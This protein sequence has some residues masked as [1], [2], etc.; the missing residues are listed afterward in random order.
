MQ[1][2]CTLSSQM[3]FG[4][5]KGLIKEARMTMVSAYFVDVAGKEG[6]NTYGGNA[7]PAT[8][9]QTTTG[10]SGKKSKSR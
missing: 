2:R 1:E 6:C 3:V 8:R 7:K 10:Y 4:T 9:S 5:L